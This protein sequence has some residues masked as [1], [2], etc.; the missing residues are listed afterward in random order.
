MRLIDCSFE[1]L[2]D[3]DLLWADLVMLSGMQVQREGLRRIAA[4]A[5]ALGRRTI[6]GGPYA[7]SQPDQAL[8]IAD[9]VGRRR[10]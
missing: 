2:R 7:S 4:R 9:H 10:A 6:L 1:E 8:E 5:R 3:E